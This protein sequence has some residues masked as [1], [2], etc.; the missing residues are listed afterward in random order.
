MF[1]LSG[2]VWRYVLTLSGSTSSRSLV[3]HFTV[4]VAL[5]RREVNGPALRGRWQIA[6]DIHS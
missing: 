6:T 3:S 4:V 1:P 5:P 2:Y